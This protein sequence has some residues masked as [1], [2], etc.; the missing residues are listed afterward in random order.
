MARQRHLSHAPLREA[1]IDIQVPAILQS[2][3]IDSLESLNIEQFQKKV[4][5]KISE[6]AFQIDQDNSQANSKIQTIGWRLESQDGTRVIQLRTNGI[7]Y[8]VINRYNDW[9][10]IKSAT[11]EIWQKYCALVEGDIMVSRIAVRYTNVLE[12]PPGVELNDYLTTVPAIPQELPQVFS[13]LFTR[14]IIPFAPN[15][16]AQITTA[17]ESTNSIVLDSDVFSQQSFDGKSLE[18]WAA[19]DSLRDIKNSI[20]FSTVTEKAIRIY[21]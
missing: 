6:F 20:F 2:S 4:P 21:E 1:L 10:D 19:L 7:T 5:I 11:Q 18:L 17:L 3:L 13:S 8:S 15:I 12:I 9:N 16:Q 14:V